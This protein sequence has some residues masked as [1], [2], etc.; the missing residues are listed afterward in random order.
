MHTDQTF[1]ARDVV[2]WSRE[3]PADPAQLIGA[4]LAMGAPV[5]YGVI[6]GHLIHGSFAALGAMATVVMPAPTRFRSAVVRLLGVA[7]VVTASAYVGALVGGRGWTT[8]AVV[9][10]LAA[11]TAVVGGFNRW[12]A[13]ATTRF[14]TFMVIATGLGPVGDPLEVARWFALGAAWAVL[15]TLIAPPLSRHR[16]GLATRPTYRSLLRRWWR[17]LR[18]IDGWRYALQLI[19]CLAL[20]EVIGVLWHQSK[21]YWIAVAVVIVVRRSGG[22]LLRAI[23]RCIGTCA[24]VFI[25]G[26]VILWV[27]PSWVIVAVVTVLAGARPLLKAR[28]YAAYATVMTPLV[29][30]LLDLWQTPSLSTA[31]YPVARYGDRLPDRTTAHRVSHKGKESGWQRGLITRSGGT[32][33]RSVSPEPRWS[34]L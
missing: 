24:G 4:A 20:A 18:E 23:Q 29:V 12:M 11:V 1:A 9:V 15:L 19:P 5:A 3:S 7:L 28:N 13:D 10:V 2:R 8:A 32:S 16:A 34:R 33:T 21:A 6:S 26:V 14:I 17:N 30:L 22:S 27:P 31:G 25:G